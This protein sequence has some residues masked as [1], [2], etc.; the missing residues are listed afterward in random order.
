MFLRVIKGI[1]NC[2]E[3]FFIV[4]VLWS[5]LSILDFVRVYVFIDNCI[6]DIIINCFDCEKVFENSNYGSSLIVFWLKNKCYSNI[7]VI[8]L[9]E[10]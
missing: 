5:E 1:I 3:I 6:S 4:F 9:F 10:L 2:I 7:F 8:K